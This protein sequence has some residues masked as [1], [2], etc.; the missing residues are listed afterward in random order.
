[1]NTHATAAIPA[2][3]LS[4]LRDELEESIIRLPV[5][6]MDLTQVNPALRERIMREGIAWND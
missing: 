6:I 5:E 1:M 4:R 3:L 2:G